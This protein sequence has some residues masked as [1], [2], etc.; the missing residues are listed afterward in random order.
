MTFDFNFWFGFLGLILTL[1]FGILSIILYKSKKYPGGLTFIEEQATGLFDML[2]KNFPEIS[3]TFNSK[4]IDSQIVLLKGFIINSGAIDIKDNMVEEKLTLN[5]PEKFKWLSAKIVDA[6]YIGKSNL[7]IIGDNQI[8]F[9]LGL[10]RKNE[11]IRFEALADIPVIKDTN[12]SSRQIFKN[13]LNFLHRIADTGKVESRP[14]ELELPKLNT[15]YRISKMAIPIVFLIYLN[16]V[17]LNFNKFNIP[18]REFQYNLSLDTNKTITAKAKPIADSNIQL[19]SSN[20]SKKDTITIAEFNTTLNQVLIKDWKGDDFFEDFI[21]RS[22]VWLFIIFFTIIFLLTSPWLFNPLM[23][24]R[25]IKKLRNVLKL[26]QKLN[27]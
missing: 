17:T 13:E 3:I 26:D 21:G 23:E 5:L 18:L 6:S 2:V 25:K 10:F 19:L 1:I 9:N 20:G 14:I 15:Y 8:V 12:L 16:I 11:F 4:P 7:E 22:M 24:Y 27:E